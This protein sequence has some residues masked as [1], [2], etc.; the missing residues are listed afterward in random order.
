MADQ[1]YIYILYSKEHDKYYVGYS[2]DP[3]RRLEEH[4]T[5]LFNTYTSK[6]RLWTLSAV[7]SCGDQ[8]NEAI[9]MERFIKKQKSRKIIEQL[10]N[11]GTLLFGSLAGLKRVLNKERNGD[12]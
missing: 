11:P 8:E 6:F 7:F 4:N 1:F 9:R 10:I 3:W 12:V 5:K 2:S